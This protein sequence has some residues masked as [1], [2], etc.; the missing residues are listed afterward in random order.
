[1]LSTNVIRASW[2]ACRS[3][4]IDMLIHEKKFNP[5]TAPKAA[6]NFIESMVF[7]KL[8]NTSAKGIE[9]AYREFAGEA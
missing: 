6:D 9:A 7:A 8:P 4:I 5:K 3:E 2:E 1:M